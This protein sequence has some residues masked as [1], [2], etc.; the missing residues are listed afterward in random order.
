MMNGLFLTPVKG[1]AG[2]I[3]IPPVRSMT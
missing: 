3:C 2:A 1:R